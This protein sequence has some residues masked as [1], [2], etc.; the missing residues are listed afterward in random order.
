VGAANV[1][2]KEQFPSLSS[3]AVFSSVAPPVTKLNFKEMVLKNAAGAAGAA[4]AAETS[5]SASASANAS[6]VVH[7]IP[8]VRTEYSRAPLSSGNIFLGAFYGPRNDGGDDGGDGDDGD[9]GGD[10]GGGG[11]GGGG[12]ISSTLIDSCDR[13]Y[14]NLYR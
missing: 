4:G 6:A 7:D 12:F 11:G 9:V 5:S 1:H 3:A 8:K 10:M 14:D 13:K 2:D